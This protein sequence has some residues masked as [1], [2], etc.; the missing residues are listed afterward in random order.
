MTES[1]SHLGTF[2]F[3]EGYF[4]G[5]IDDG[6]NAGKEHLQELSSL[7]EKYYSGAPTIYISD[8][9]HSYSIDPIATQNLIAN[10]NIAYAAVVLH[11]SDQEKSYPLEKIMI[12][13]VKL[14]QFHNLENAVT[15]AKTK[16]C[17]LKMQ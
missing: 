17:G 7:I 14:E 1:I 8:R 3:F 11:S 2:E 12:S 5:R 6:V 15:W 4:I 13:N 16:H 9:V 10:S